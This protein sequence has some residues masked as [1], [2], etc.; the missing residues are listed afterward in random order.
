MSARL[1]GLLTTKTTVLTSTGGRRPGS[2]AVDGSSGAANRDPFRFL[3][4]KRPLQ[5]SKLIALPR[6]TAV[7][8][9][10]TMTFP[11]ARDYALLRYASTDGRGGRWPVCHT[12]YG[13]VSVAFRKVAA[14]DGARL[15][16]SSALV[17]SRM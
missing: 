7:D 6:T 12:D 11:C 13:V 9:P 15:P 8:D 5:D 17:P 16:M 1:I 3:P 4:W 2:G 14:H 10:H